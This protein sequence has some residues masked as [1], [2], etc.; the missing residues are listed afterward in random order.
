MFMMARC[1]I[2][3]ARHISLGKNGVDGGEI[4]AVFL[5]RFDWPR[6]ELD[7]APFWKFNGFKREKDA[8]FKDCVNRFHHEQA[9]RKLT[10]IKRFMC[11]TL[12]FCYSY[13]SAVMSAIIFSNSRP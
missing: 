10:G 13:N 9:A 2:M 6:L 12:R 3:F 4:L 5:G 1:D 7:F 11:C 8:P